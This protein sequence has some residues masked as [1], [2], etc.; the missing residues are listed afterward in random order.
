MQST[1]TEDGKTVY[2]SKTEGDNGSK[3][4]FLVAYESQNGDR[5]YG[6]FCTNCESFDNAM[7]AMGRIKCNR[8]ENFRKPTQWDAAHE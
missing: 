6:W 2:V 1:E 8:C 4:P 7:D 3:G 5:R